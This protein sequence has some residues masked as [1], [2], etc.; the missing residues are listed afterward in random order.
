MSFRWK[1]IEWIG[2]RTLKFEIDFD[3][4]AH[5]SVDSIDEVYLKF[6]DSYFFTEQGFLSS[7]ISANYTV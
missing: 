5:M 4:P 2:P 3:K 7:Y 1:A 6:I